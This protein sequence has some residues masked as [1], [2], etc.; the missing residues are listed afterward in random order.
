MSKGSKRCIQVVHGEAPTGITCIVS[1]TV[2]QL[3]GGYWIGNVLVLDQA[4]SVPVIED[5]AMECSQLPQP[6]GSDTCV[7]LSDGLKL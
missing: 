6:E 7:A 3:A 4:V 2:L 1:Q 5:R